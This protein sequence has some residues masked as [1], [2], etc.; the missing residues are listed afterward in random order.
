MEAEISP[1]ELKVL[2][3][4]DDRITLKFVQACLQKE[5]C[6]QVA[7]AVD[8]RAAFEMIDQNPPDLLITDWMMPNL[9][10]LD[11]CRLVR[12]RQAEDYIYIILLTVRGEHQDIVSGLAAGADDYVVKPFDQDELLAR[13]RAGARM[14]AAQ[15]ALRQAN[16]ELKAA[17]LQIKT[18]KGL[19]PICMD[20]KK[21]RDDKDYW[22]EIEEY[23]RQTTDAEFSHGLCPDCMAK[24]MASLDKFPRRR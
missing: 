22:Q 1:G 10:G 24:R 13:V 8:G 4:D 11:L 7:T 5:K 16:R 20:C 15:K 3:V 18:L 12:G 6:Y 14:V 19:L 9:D 17:F 2:A 21:I 23:I